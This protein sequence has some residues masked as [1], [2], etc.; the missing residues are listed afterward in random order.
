MPKPTVQSRLSGGRPLGGRPIATL[1]FGV[2]ML[3]LVAEWMLFSLI[4]GQIGWFPTIVIA[5]FKGGFGLI[6][7]GFVLKRMQSG[8]RN[9]GRGTVSGEKAGL[10]LGEPLLAILGA[11]LICLPGFVATVIGLALFAPSVRL[12]LLDRFGRGASARN[13]MIDLGP[14][15]YREI[16]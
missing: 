9:T 16:D 14:Q 10:R 5:I 12:A 2:T 7:L 8:L 4:A 3:W 15:D 6:L 1:L 13:D 11:I